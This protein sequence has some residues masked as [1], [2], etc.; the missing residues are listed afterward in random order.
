CRA[1]RRRA[2]P[3]PRCARGRAGRSAGGAPGPDPAV[4]LLPGPTRIR[5]SSREQNTNSSSRSKYFAASPGENV[6]PGWDA[7]PP[8]LGLCPWS[9]IQAEEAKATAPWSDSLV[10]TRTY[11]RVEDEQHAAGGEQQVV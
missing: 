2:R 3:R 10:R 4:R 6:S 8:Q 11:R 1:G 9:T 5:I 7:R